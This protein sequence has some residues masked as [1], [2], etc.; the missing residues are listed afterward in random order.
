MDF[1]KKTVIVCTVIACII[2]ATCMAFLLNNSYVSSVKIAAINYKKLKN[3]AECYKVK[4]N[5]KDLH[6]QVMYQIRNAEKSA[7]SEYWKIRKQDLSADEKEARIKE[8][9]E[10]W[11]TKSE[12]LRKKI[13]EIKATLNSVYSYINKTRE[14][15]R[16]L[17]I[18]KNANL[19]LND[20]EVVNTSASVIDITSDVADELNKKFE[21][22]AEKAKEVLSQKHKLLN[23]KLKK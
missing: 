21:K 5:L 23:E 12:K 1:D 7:K 9:D 3:I 22:Y 20:A 17:A 4:N 2:C 18:K 15:A 6:E 11:K 19:L 14:V 13:A 8:I 16:K 10:N